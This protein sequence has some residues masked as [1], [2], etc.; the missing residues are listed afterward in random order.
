MNF[1]NGCVFGKQQSITTTK[2]GNV[3]KQQHS[4]N[5][6]CTIAVRNEQRNTARE[7]RDFSGLFN[8]LN[9]RFFALVRI[10]RGAFSNTQFGECLTNCIRADTHAVQSR[11]GIWRCVSNTRLS[12]ENNC[13]VSYAWSNACIGNTTFK[14]KQ[15]LRDH[16]GELPENFGVCRF[17]LA[18]TS[19]SVRYP[20]TRQHG[21]GFSVVTHGD[22][23]HVCRATNCLHKYFA[24]RNF[25]AFITALQQNFFRIACPRIYV[26]LVIQRLTSCSANLCSNQPRIITHW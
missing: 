26:V 22:G 17:Q 23:E 21:N 10:S 2:F 9:H 1:T 7:Q 15:A 13:T 6:F 19:S 14:R 4:A 3:T 20:F 18:S 24:L 25:A 5:H 12:I 11:H 8:F 16:L